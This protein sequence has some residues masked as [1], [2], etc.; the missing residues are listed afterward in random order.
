MKWGTFTL[1]TLKEFAE[2]QGLDIN[3][4]SFSEAYFD[5][6]TCT[7]P[8]GSNYGTKGK[9]MPPN[10]TATV[11]ESAHYNLTGNSKKENDEERRKKFQP[12]KRDR[13]APIQY[14]WEHSEALFDF[15]VCET[16][17][18]ERYGTDGNCQKPNREATPESDSPKASSAA[19]YKNFLQFQAEFNALGDDIGG[20]NGKKIKETAGVRAMVLNYAN[21]MAGNNK[22]KPEAFSSL[23]EKLQQPD[24]NLDRAA[25]HI[26]AATLKKCM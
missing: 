14:E 5:F 24:I 1:S 17:G 23:A 16:P 15:K 12:R 13:F 21:L 9:C 2:M 22:I 11:Q 7:R 3:D 25:S 8:D 18:G 19:I 6:K 4:H 20:A 26:Y 10:K